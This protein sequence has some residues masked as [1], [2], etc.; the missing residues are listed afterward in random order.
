YEPQYLPSRPV[1]DYSPVEEVSLPK[2]KPSKRCLNNSWPNRYITFYGP[3]P[4]KLHCAKDGFVRSKIAPKGIR[5][6]PVDFGRR[7][8]DVKIPSSEK[9]RAKSKSKQSKTSESTS[10]NTS[11]STQGG[12][13][14]NNVVVEDEVREVRLMGR[15]KA[16]KKL[17][18]S[19]SSSADGD[20]GFV[21]MLVKVWANAT[22]SLFA[23]KQTKSDAYV[24]IKQKEQDMKQKEL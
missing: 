23:T 19:T 14:F 4:K 1:G 11:E 3:R 13:N 6:K 15:D 16:K 18:S 2:K 8:K 5:I 12:F 24:K 22:T 10:F 21:K 17:A 9:S 20:E 7:Y